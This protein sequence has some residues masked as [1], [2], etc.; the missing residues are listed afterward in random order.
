MKKIYLHP[1]PVRI[2]HW[3]NAVSFVVLI[4]TGLQIRYRDMMNIMLF[5]DAV[6]VHNI[7]GFVLIGNFFLWLVYYIA[8]GKIRLYIPPLS[9]KKFVMGC[10]TQARYYGYGI[11]IG[12]PNPHH[13]TADNKFNPL[14]K[15]AY[16]AIMAILIPLQLVTGLLLWDVKRFSSWISLAGGI[17]TVDTVHVFLFLFF[18]SFLFVHVYLATLG[19]TPTEHIKA[20]FTGYEELEETGHH[21][22]SS[23]S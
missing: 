14:Q 21:P 23:H 12:E 16:L 7:A 20:M 8:T 11:F 18:T 22:A 9:L 2:W 19:H 10:I 1:L 17:K 15:V 3:V 13:G 5:R 4:V 6:D